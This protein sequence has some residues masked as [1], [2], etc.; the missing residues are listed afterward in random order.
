MQISLK[1]HHIQFLG[2][3]QGLPTFHLIQAVFQVSKIVLLACLHENT[4]D[5]G[6][7]LNNPHRSACQNF[8]AQCYCNKKSSKAGKMGE[9]QINSLLETNFYM[10]PHIFPFT[11]FHYITIYGYVY[12]YVFCL[13]SISLNILLIQQSLYI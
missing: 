13:Y 5:L 1:R 2:M 11:T 12:G 7:V 8:L 3:Q 6:V 9:R 10:I 4:K